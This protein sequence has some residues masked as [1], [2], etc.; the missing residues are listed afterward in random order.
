MSRCGSPIEIYWRLLQQERR[1]S[2]IGGRVENVN[3]NEE[4]LIELNERK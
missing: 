2:G 1:C 3:V 4:N